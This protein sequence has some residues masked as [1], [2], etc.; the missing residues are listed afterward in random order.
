MNSEFQNM[1][2]AA[3]MVHLDAASWD[4]VAKQ[5][6]IQGPSVKITK[7]HV[8]Y[9]NPRHPEYKTGVLMN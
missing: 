7:C 1:I 4:L 3:C 5:K 6:Q 8:R 2:K 9:M